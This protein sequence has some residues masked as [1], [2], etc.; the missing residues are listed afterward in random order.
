M[1]IRAVE[2]IDEVEGEFY[3]ALYSYKIIHLLSD[4]CIIFSARSSPD[5]QSAANS[6]H[7]APGC[8]KKRGVSQARS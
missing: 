5:H 2:A 1:G 8:A 3:N 6:K 7:A 4:R